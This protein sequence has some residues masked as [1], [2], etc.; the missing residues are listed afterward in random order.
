MERAI[1]LALGGLIALAAATA[2][3]RAAEQQFACKGQ[4]V[5]GETMPGVAPKPI[6]MN[7]TLGERGKLALKLGD[8]KALSPRVTGNNKIQ[9]KFATKEFIGEYFHY[10]GD[11]FLIY[12]SGLL[13]K[14]QCS[15]A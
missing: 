8:G 5:Q 14:L 2:P 12:P 15:H 13:G 3:G 7:F 9:L 1:S 4:V 10:T 6:D 11:L